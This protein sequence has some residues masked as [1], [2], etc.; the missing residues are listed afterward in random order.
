[1]MQGELTGSCLCVAVR[2][3][4]REGF[5]MRPYACHCT[6]CQKRTGSAFSL[7]MLF[8]EQDFR[9]D[10]PLDQGTVRQPN[11]TVSTI[12]G[13]ELC[14]TRIHAI[15]SARPGFGSLRCGT[16]DRSREVVPAAHLWIASKQAWIVLPEDVPTLQEQPRSTGEWLALVGVG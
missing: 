11:G 6:D 2:Y 4:L 10:G 16:L 15:N 12:Y 7:H 8:A 9:L 3:T 13:C 5:R 1:M 14:N